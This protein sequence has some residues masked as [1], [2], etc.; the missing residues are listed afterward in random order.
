MFAK[1]FLHRVFTPFLR[2]PGGCQAVNVA[3]PIN[4]LNH[5]IPTHQSVPDGPRNEKGKSDLTLRRTETHH[6][7]TYIR[8]TTGMF[9]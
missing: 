3:E 2:L 8:R 6:Q 5:T 9:P 7:P 4:H 1:R